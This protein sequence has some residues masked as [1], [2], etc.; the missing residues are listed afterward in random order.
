MFPF[1]CVLRIDNTS[2]FVFINILLLFYNRVDGFNFPDF[3]S[4]LYIF[5][6]IFNLLY[7]KVQ[8]GLHFYI[9]NEE[10]VEKLNHKNDQTY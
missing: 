7:L 4:T 8:R 6:K 2:S 5:M 1:G 10:N 9:L 3:P